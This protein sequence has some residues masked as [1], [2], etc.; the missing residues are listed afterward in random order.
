MEVSLIA[1]C[2]REIEDQF[3]VKIVNDLSLLRQVYELRYQVYCTERGF[4]KGAQQP[5]Q[6]GMEFDDFD[7]RSRHIAL[8]D[9]QTSELVGTARMV[10]SV[11]G[12]LRSSFPM[13]TVCSPSLFNK[14]PLDTT[15]EVSRFAIS[16]QRRSATSAVLMRMG[17]VQ[18]LVRLSAELGVTHWCAVMEPTLLRLLRMTSIYFEPLGPLVEYHGLRQPCFNSLDG[19]LDA[20]CEER[21]EIWHYLTEG[22]KTWQGQRAPIWQQ[23]SNQRLA[24]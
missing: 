13:Q 10:R 24:A 1:K 22:G 14:L 7:V 12:S 3:E 15:V 11:P 16:K 9:R 19:L 4:E 17:L 20:V 8:I 21:P 6:A 23:G 18:G 2:L 5:G